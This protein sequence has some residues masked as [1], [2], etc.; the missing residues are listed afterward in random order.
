MPNRLSFATDASPIVMDGETAAHPDARLWIPL[1]DLDSIKAPSNYVKQEAIDGYIAREKA[2]KL[3]EHEQDVT[4]GAA[5]DRYT[6]RIAALGWWTAEGGYSTRPCQDEAAEAVALTEWW[7]VSAHRT[8]I[9]YNCKG[10]D[11]PYLTARSWLLRVPCPAPDFGKY[12]RVAIT[13]L[14]HMLTFNEGKYDKGLM[15]RSLRAFAGR[16]GL[17]AEDDEHSGADVP[18]L[19]RAGDWDAV[20]AHL[21]ADL[22]ITVGLAQRLGVLWHEEQPTLDLRHVGDK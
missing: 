3:A 1:P 9:G 17:A 10:F 6:G 16:F 7:A 14:Y 11:L 18:A 4:N 8:I 5:L 15:P 19:V 12:G 22:R 20:L 13:D 21:L 2:A